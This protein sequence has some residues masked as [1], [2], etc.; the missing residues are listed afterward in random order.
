VLFAAL[1]LENNVGIPGK[2]IR[3][4]RLEDQLGGTG[5][6]AWWVDVLNTKKPEPVVGSGLQIAGDGGNE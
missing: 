1:A 6:R 5:L 3:F 4:E 2:P